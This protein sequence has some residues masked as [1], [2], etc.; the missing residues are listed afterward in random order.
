M[1][2]ETLLE[3]IGL[4]LENN[5]KSTPEYTGNGTLKICILQR[6]WV[7]VGRYYQEGD[8]CRLED[9]SCIRSWGTT[10]GLGELAENGTLTNTKLDLTPTVRFHRLGI[11][12]TID[13]NEKKWK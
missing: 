13:C 2:K 9:A 3:L 1:K 12:A 10:K 5:P 8:D 11:V 6:G 4:A 7:F